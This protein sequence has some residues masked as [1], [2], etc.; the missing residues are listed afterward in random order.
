MEGIG[1]AWS[2]RLDIESQFDSNIVQLLGI[3]GQILVPPCSD[4]NFKSK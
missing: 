3:P 1:L 2:N 4:S